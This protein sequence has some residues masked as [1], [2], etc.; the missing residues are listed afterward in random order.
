MQCMKL[1]FLLA[2]YVHHLIIVIGILT[3]IF[4]LINKVP[5]KKLKKTGNQAFLSLYSV[6]LEKLAMLHSD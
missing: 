6:Y 2:L 1:R 5:N 3:A 4:H